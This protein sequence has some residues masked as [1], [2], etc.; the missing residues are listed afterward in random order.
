VVAHLLDDMH[1][2]VLVHL[3]LNA[4]DAEH[5]LRGANRVGVSCGPPAALA[6][7]A[8]TSAATE[9]DEVLDEL[10]GGGFGL[11]HDPAKFSGDEPLELLGAHQ[12]DEP[13]NGRALQDGPNGAGL[14]VTERIR[15]LAQ[16]P[17]GEVVASNDARPGGDVPHRLVDWHRRS[18]LGEPNRLG[19]SLRRAPPRPVH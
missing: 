19:P 6:G 9:L 17:A 1:V 3:A 4:G 13:A 18:R 16:R 10:R 2:V 7:G 14:R 8:V 11:G 5:N 12:F 15:D